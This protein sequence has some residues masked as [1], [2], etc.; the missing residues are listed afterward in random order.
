[1]GRRAGRVWWPIVIGVG[2]VVVAIPGS[3]V[4]QPAAGTSL[5]GIPLGRFLFTPAVF[6][7]WE[8]R[9]NLFRR[10]EG[11]RES[12]SIWRAG[13]DLGLTL[14]LSSSELSFRYSP[15]Y[16]DYADYT[17]ATNWQHELAL[18]AHLVSA[19]GLVFDAGASYFDGSRRVNLFDPGG[20]VPFADDPFTSWTW[21]AKA[22]Y[23]ITGRNGI[24]ARID[25]TAIEFDDPETTTFYDY[26]R[27][28][29]GIGWLHQWSP[30]VVVRLGYDHSTLDPENT[31][32]ARASDQDTISVEVRGELTP[33]L[34]SDL[35]LG[36]SQVEY[37]LP[38]EFQQFAEVSGWVASGGLGYQLGHGGRLNLNL[39]RNWNP[40][41]Q[42][43]ALGYVATSV[44]L[45][46]GLN[47]D[48]F[49][50]Q[51]GARYQENDYEEP[52]SEA[53]RSDEIRGASARV[54]YALSPRL[55]LSAEYGF[56]DRSSDGATFDYSANS[57][58]L[59]A[60][61]TF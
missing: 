14:P 35:T 34:S 5:E 25:S 30:N 45:G 29:L 7:G 40:S 58:Q 39:S 17:L 31:F 61:F 3:A 51:V 1:M 46:Y 18:R 19:T 16:E 48:P 50:F 41:N 54:E 52:L 28:S 38:A 32:Q 2:M 9:D 33:V 42:G 26:T 27:E 24:S 47:R 59:R 12:G 21:N 13:A 10:P 49:S 53:P 20:E 57:V 4:A 56:E 23:W 37:D 11:E 36:W 22:D 8:W 55:G 6:A 43:L 15:E 44:R 60:R